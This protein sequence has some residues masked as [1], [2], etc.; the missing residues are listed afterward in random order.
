MLRRKEAINGKRQD[1]GR[2]LI[3]LLSSRGPLR[4]FQI[5]AFCDKKL[6]LVASN[7]K[8]IR[9][10]RTESSSGDNSWLRSYSVPFPSRQLTP[11]L[12]PISTPP[13][14]IFPLHRQRCS[15]L[16]SFRTRIFSPFPFSIYSDGKVFHKE[17]W[18]GGSL[19]DS[20]VTSRNLQFGRSV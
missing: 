16:A 5:Q 7:F 11:N 4:L 8:V 1:T 3:A 14:I 12:A 13:L 9:S 2:L 15:D 10:N 19:Q 20:S 6:D 18:V 17:H